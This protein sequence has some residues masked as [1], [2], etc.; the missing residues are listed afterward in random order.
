MKVRFAIAPHGASL[1]GSGLTAFI[2]AVEAGGF[3]GI[4]LSDL[5]AAAVLD[6]MLGLA[7]AAGRTR[8]LRLGANIV[9]LGRNPFLLAKELAQLD[10]LCHGR[11]LLS[12]VTGLGGAREREALGLGDARRGEVLEEVLA[13][14]RAWWAGDAVDH[15]SPRWSYA[16][17]ASAARPVQ[18][19][20]EVWRGG[21]GPQAL[22]RVGRVADGWLGAQLTPGECAGAVSTIQA[23]A[24]RAGREIDPEHFGLSIAYARTA[25]GAED[26]AALMSRTRRSDVDPLELVPV[27]DEALRAFIHGCVESGLS[28]FVVRPAL[29]VAS[30]DEEIGW[31]ADAILDLQT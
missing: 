28:K 16:A 1:S 8:R 3:D 17:M 15:R 6:P 14:A 10:Q 12:F 19:P 22:D 23:A 9:P 20:L 5:P 26:L 25:P 27:G 24:A 2:D 7:L 11:L 30:W 18:D 31:L 21:R 13:L 4:W 29:P